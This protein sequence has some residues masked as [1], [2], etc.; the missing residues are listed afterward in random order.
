[1]TGYRDNR[2]VCPACATLLDPASVGG[3]IIDVC[4]DCAGIWVDWFDGELTEVARETPISSPAVAVAAGGSMACPRCQRPLDGEGYLD[5]GA[6]VLR[7]AECTGAFVPRAGMALLVSAR[8]PGAG[9]DTEE[10]G[11]SKLI[12]VIRRWLERWD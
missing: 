6:T 2:L 11:L 8:R 3:A 1:M 10:S 9:A 4:R 7:C 12:A 5:T